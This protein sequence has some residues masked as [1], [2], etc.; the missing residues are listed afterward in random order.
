MTAGDHGKKGPWTTSDHLAH[1]IP[2]EIDAV[3]QE[4]AKPAGAQ[5]L[6]RHEL[7]VG[8]YAA[9]AH[10]EHKD[11]ASATM[12]SRSTHTELMRGS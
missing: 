3:H 9:S 10:V 8:A 2:V 12:K 5:L 11:S 6:G 1:A 4:G 7:A